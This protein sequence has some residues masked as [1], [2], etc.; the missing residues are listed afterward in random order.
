VSRCGGPAPEVRD[1]CTY[2]LPSAHHSIVIVGD[3]VSMTYVGALRAALKDSPDW[4][5]YSYGSFGCAFTDVLIEN[6]DASL[7]DACTER[8]AAAVAAI[9]DIR[10]DLVLVANAYLPRTEA[11]KDSPLSETAW[12]QSTERMVQK[13]ATSTQKVAFLAAP[14]ADKDPGSCYTKQSSPT[15]CVG[16]ITTAWSTRATTEQALAAKLKGAWIDS[17]PWFCYQGLCPAFVGTTPTRIDQVH[18]TQPYAVKIGPSVAEVLNR[19]HLVT[20][21]A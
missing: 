20:E 16:R 13:F 17:S 12:A 4:K 2:G 5:L 21:K 6:S 7:Q 14:P 3:S 8:K 1:K 11:G 18:M 15:D 9:K 10:P 19:M